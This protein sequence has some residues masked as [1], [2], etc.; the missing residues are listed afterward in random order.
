VNEVAFP[1]IGS[2]DGFGGKAKDKETFYSF[3]GFTTPT[4]IYRYDMTTGKSTS[5]GSR[6]SISIR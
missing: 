6:K 1:G 5:F 4:T 3:T 2:A